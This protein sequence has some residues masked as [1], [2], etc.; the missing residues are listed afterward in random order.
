[1]LLSQ[2]FIDDLKNRAVLLRGIRLVLAVL[3][4]FISIGNGQEPPKPLLVDEVGE[5]CSEDLMARM[6]NFM[7]Q[8]NT[9]PTAKGVVI[10]HGR[11]DTHGRNQLLSRYISTRYPAMRGFDSSRLRLLEGETREEQMIQF[12]IVPAGAKELVYKPYGAASYSESILFDRAWVGFNRWAGS[13]DIY[14]DGF[15]DLGCD[16][17]PNRALFAKIVRE[18]PHLDAFLIVYTSPENRSRGVRLASFA[19][20]DLVGNFKVPRK[21]I[22]AINGGTRKEPE[23]EL[24]LIPRGQRPPRPDSSKPPINDF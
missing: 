13:L 6:D 12:W 15:Y 1:M 11:N 21:R 19:L 17:P 5:V 4:V 2:F 7:V 18:N 24:W 22:R 20:N 3:L 9:N 23:I 14:S 16:F 8:L 10:F